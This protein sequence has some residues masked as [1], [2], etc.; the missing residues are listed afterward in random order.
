[1]SEKCE[2]IRTQM[3]KSQW[4]HNR[5]GAVAAATAGFCV[6]AFFL[7]RWH[8]SATG[9]QGSE[10]APNLEVTY[11]NLESP[12]EE[13][14][15]AK[16]ERLRDLILSS[17]ASN[18]L[19]TFQAG[20]TSLDAQTLKTLWEFSRGKLN[21]SDPEDF[22]IASAILEALAGITPRLALTLADDAGAWRSQMLRNVVGV[23]GQ[24]DQAAALEWISKADSGVRDP[25]LRALLESLGDR[26]RE[27]AIRL[28]REQVAKGIVGKRAWG[29]TEFFEE[30]AREDTGKAVVAAL[31]HFHF[32]GKSWGLESSLKVWAAKDP[33]A[34]FAWL[35]EKAGD[36]S[37]TLHTELA[38]DL[39]GT[40]SD[41]SPKEAADFLLTIKESNPFDA[42]AR[43]VIDDWAAISFDDAK[44]WIAG[45]KDVKRREHLEFLLV[46][47]ARRTGDRNDG[48]AYALEKFESNSGMS[49]SL[50]LLVSS[51][52]G[53]DLPA[54]IPWVQEIAP[55]DLILEEF[56]NTLLHQWRTQD[57][58][59]AVRH[60]DLMP[61]PIRRAEDYEFFALNYANS[62]LDAAREWAN[63]LP[64]SEDRDRA[65]IGVAE[66]WSKRNPAEAE[67]W[68]KSLDAGELRDRAASNHIGTIVEKDIP[69]ALEMA[70]Q[71][72]D[73]FRRDHS[74][75]F[76]L[77][78]WLEQD[79]TAAEA[80]IREN[81][82]LSATSKWRLLG[83]P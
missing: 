72:A 79:R 2:N 10:K 62:D 13:S 40:W 44:A 6:L 54:A 83:E 53:E 43:H 66:T 60:L 21:Y 58:A 36:L 20:L 5:T 15:E 17:Q 47:G 63:R 26:D 77:G 34:A 71:L 81:N 28:F 42:A 56:Y 39:L 59:Q 16:Q 55:N 32:T 19:L 14:L 25:A 69:K 68:I 31:E 48:I 12:F 52:V 76:V 37:T 67:A 78:K 74:L 61:D 45:V 29:A 27:A 82:D 80:A 7:G 75:E 73:P 22:A 65:L 35:Q 46:N 70:S 30:W 3:A 57:I 50:Y 64:E 49:H 33:Q 23:W 4:A 41:R 18:R 38:G 9:K 24:I 51:V 8:A 11:A 1:M